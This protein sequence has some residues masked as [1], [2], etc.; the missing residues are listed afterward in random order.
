MKK[1]LSLIALFCLAVSPVHAA[2]EFTVSGGDVGAKPI[3]VVPFATPADINFDVA[4]IVE[5]DL[6]RSGLFDALPRTDML[7]KPTAVNQIDYRNWRTLN[8]ENLVLGSLS[9]SPQGGVAVRF[10]LM[11]VYRGQQMIGFDMPAVGPEQLRVVSHQIADLIYEKLTG[12]KGYFNTQISYVTAAGYGLARRFQLIV[13]DADGYNPRTI[14]SSKEPLMSPAWSPDGKKL[15]YVGYERG[16]SA[17]YVHT[18]ASGE[19]RK[20]VAEKGING[21]PVWSPDGSKMVVTLSFETNPDLYIIDI[22]SGQRRRL[23]DHYAIDTEAAFSPDGGSLA[24]TSDRGGSAQVY[25]MPAAG[26]EPKRVTFQ[27][28]QNLRPRYSPDGKSLA[29]VNNEGGRYSIGLVDL[30]TGSLRVLTD[31]PLDESP[32]FAPNGGVII[33]A[34]TGSGSAELGTVTVDGRVHQRLRQPGEVREPAWGPYGR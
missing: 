29:V 34:T 26:G 9:R 28:K 8:R 14:A 5:A 15:A 33:Y 16:R 1:L 30:Q 18:L 13:A 2:L 27:G 4:G 17:I 3:A 25:V 19:L 23:T 22:A 31:G 24:F 12:Q 7:E 21:A 10:F 11:D 32:S 20:F 6:V